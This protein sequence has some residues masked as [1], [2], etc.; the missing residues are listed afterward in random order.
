MLSNMKIDNAFIESGYA[1]WKNGFNKNTK[2][3]FNQHEKSVVHLSAVNRFKEVP[4]S[5]DDIVGIVTK[6]PLEIQQKNLQL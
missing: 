5:T 6:N 3:G 1:N 4:G 2:K